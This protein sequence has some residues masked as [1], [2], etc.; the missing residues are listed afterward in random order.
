MTQENHFRKGIILAGGSGT[1]LY[2][3]TRV[4]S[5]QLL[6]VYDKPMIYYPLSVLMLADIRDILLIVRI[7][8]L[9]TRHISQAIAE[10]AR[11]C[12]LTEYLHKVVIVVGANDE[13]PLLTHVQDESDVAAVLVKTV[14]VQQKHLWGVLRYLVRHSNKLPTEDRPMQQCLEE[15]P[16]EWRFPNDH[17]SDG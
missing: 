17:T 9:D 11:L 14:G 16:G 10:E 3:L 15:T 1:R 4:T 13:A 7:V 5:K 12:L 8:V 2:P 6:P